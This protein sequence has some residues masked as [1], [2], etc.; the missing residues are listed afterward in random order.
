M[1]FELRLVI[2]GLA[3]FSW[4]GLAG[5]AIAAWLSRRPIGGTAPDRATRVLQIRLLP[6]AMAL[7]VSALAVTAFL[8][9]EPRHA[10]ESFG[11]VLVSLAACGAALLLSTLVRTVI[12][13]ERTRRIWAGWMVGADPIALTG[14]EV[15]AYAITTPFPVV[16]VVGFWR[17]R[18]VIARSVLAACTDDEVRAIL[19]HERHHLTRR[20]NLQRALLALSPDVLGFLPASRRLLRAWHDAA[21]DA[22]DDFARRATAVGGVTLAAALVKV[23]RLAPTGTLAT[24]LPA[25]ALYRGENLERRVRR[26]LAPVH[27]TP[28]TRRVGALAAA[29]V[30]I[31]G[32]GLLTL[33]RLHLA[34]EA[35]VQLL[36]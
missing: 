29:A 4:A 24:T 11:W 32:L 17:P 10:T 33:D 16:A 36:P 30:A 12:V 2:V 1:S 5:T 27:E 21:E 23:A 34:M 8:R 3:A 15:P 9:F 18:L 31:V 28:A 6:P 22:A 35:A 19:C 20:D 25:S 7:T 26:L 13:A 14:I